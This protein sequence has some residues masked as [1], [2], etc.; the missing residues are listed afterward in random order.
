MNTEF[1][2]QYADNQFAQMREQSAAEAGAS[3]LVLADYLLEQLEQD[4]AAFDEADAK[5]QHRMF[6]QCSKLSRRLTGFA[7]KYSAQTAERSR[8]ALETI[9]SGNKMLEM[10]RQEYEEYEQQTQEIL[11]VHDKLCTS[12][13]ELWEQQSELERQKKELDAMRR[14]ISELTQL[15]DLIASTQKEMEALCTL[16]E[17][18]QYIT[19]MLGQSG[20]VDDDSALRKSLAAFRALLNQVLADA[21]ALQRQIQRRQE[22]G[23]AL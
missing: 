23:G 12:K 5:E 17:A 16:V 4:P 2:R 18:N 3:L 22:P 21:R 1:I 15:R 14:D 19:D 7:E 10:T 11:A 20:Y 13:L 8:K 9:R 6:L